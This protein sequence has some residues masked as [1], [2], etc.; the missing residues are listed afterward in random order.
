MKHDLRYV[1]LEPTVFTHIVSEGPVRIATGVHQIPSSCLHYT[2]MNEI[3]ARSVR[4][5]Q[6]S[7]VHCL[8]S[9]V[10]VET[11]GSQAL[12]C[13]PVPHVSQ[14]PLHKMPNI[15]LA[16]TNNN[17]K[18]HIKV[19]ARHRRNEDL[20]QAPL[21]ADK[22]SATAKLDVGLLCVSTRSMSKDKMSSACKVFHSLRMIRSVARQLCQSVGHGRQLFQSAALHVAHTHTRQTQRSA[23]DHFIGDR[24]RTEVWHVV[25]V[26]GVS[27]SFGIESLRTHDEHG[28]LYLLTVCAL[29]GRSRQS[30]KHPHYEVLLPT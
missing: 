22:R 4:L 25:C 21:V 2:W 5:Y 28:W 12:V 19:A 3:K 11:V 9:G 23:R 8:R 6:C 7:T 15:V 10:A 18:H 26:W 17:N 14:T 13:G 16:C 29:P 27:V 1:H 20:L 30:E 24:L